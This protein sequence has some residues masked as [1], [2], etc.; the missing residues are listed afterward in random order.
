MK[1]PCFNAAGRPSV[2]GLV[3]ATRTGSVFGFWMVISLGD[4]VVL[5][6]IVCMVIYTFGDD[7]FSD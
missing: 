6:M 3:S 5:M 2:G 1:H 7:I 4:I